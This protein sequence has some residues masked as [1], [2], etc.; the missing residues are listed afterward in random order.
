[1]AIEFHTH[2]CVLRSLPGEQ[3]GQPALPCRLRRDAIR[4]FSRERFSQLLFRA[5]N[6]GK[7]HRKMHSAA[8]ARKANVGQRCLIT[9]QPCE[10]TLNRCAQC[11]VSPCRQREQGRIRFACRLGRRRRL[12]KHDESIRTAKTERIDGGEPRTIAR[13]PVAILRI[14]KEWTRGEIDLWVGFSEVEA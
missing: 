10:V 7:P 12:F 14:D 13:G 9:S 3:K 4:G 11:G 6:R 8:S 2:S 5:S 1:M